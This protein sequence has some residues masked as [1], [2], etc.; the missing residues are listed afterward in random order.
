MGIKFRKLVSLFLIFTFVMCLSSCDSIDTLDS[1]AVKYVSYEKINERL[2]FHHIR[3]EGTDYYYL[4]SEYEVPEEYTLFG[5]EIEV[6]LVDMGGD[7]YDET[8]TE[9]AYTYNGDVD[10]VY[11]YYLSAAFTKDKSKGVTD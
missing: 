6:T 9:K 4:D 10:N 1:S 7:A 11:I 8:K 5:D 3:Y 2:L